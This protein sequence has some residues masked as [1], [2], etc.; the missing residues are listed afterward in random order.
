M[1]MGGDHQYLSST[2]ITLEH[3]KTADTRL[4]LPL[5][6]TQFLST[7]LNLLKKIFFVP[8][9]YRP[10]TRQKTTLLISLRNFRRPPQAVYR[11]LS[12]FSCH[13]RSDARTQIRAKSTVSVGQIGRLPD[14][15]AVLVCPAL[16]KAD[17]SR[18]R[19]TQDR[20]ARRT[21]PGFV[22]AGAEA[23][24]FCPS[25][26]LNSLARQ[27]KFPAMAIDDDAARRRRQGFRRPADHPR[28]ATLSRHFGDRI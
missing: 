18:F 27:S 16:S 4:F 17:R 14:S 2:H 28:V 21:R 5:A 3:S 1:T 22:P 24:S 23:I 10:R 25:C 26:G 20:H 6:P 19:K 15:F 13:S 7:N 12:A 11:L 9:Y 8:K